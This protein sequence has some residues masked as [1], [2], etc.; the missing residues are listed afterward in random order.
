MADLIRNGYFDDDELAPWRQCVRNEIGEAWR[1]LEDEEPGFPRT[2][3]V[4]TNGGTLTDHNWV[5]LSTYNLR[6]TDND[7]I[8]QDLGS[9]ARA[10]GEF[11]VWAHCTPI[12]REAGTF[13]AFVCYADHTFNFGT[14]TRDQLR[15]H[16]GPTAL[17][18]PVEDKVVT[19]VMLCV[20][21]SDAPWYVSGISLPGV[22]AKTALR[23]PT[24][25]RYIENRL[26]RVEE[27]VDRL[28]VML[29]KGIRPG[30]N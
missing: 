3:W 4:Y 18:V 27:K 23:P 22:E 2:S 10:G 15:R 11:T 30:R 25:A 12:D 13:Y 24:S 6:M 29:A 16:V 26:A 5:F 28:Y 1:C 7:A 8:A 17:K 20:V 9:D 14:L 21:G 19:K